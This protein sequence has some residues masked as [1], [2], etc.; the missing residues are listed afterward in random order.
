MKVLIDHLAC[1]ISCLKGFSTFFSHTVLH[2]YWPAATGEITK[3]T[4]GEQ[5]PHA[6]A[7]ELLDLCDRL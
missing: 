3:V 1:C 4:L 2:H 6:V 7:K 5:P